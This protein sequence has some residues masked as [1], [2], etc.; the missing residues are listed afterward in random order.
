M[1]TQDPLVGLAAMSCINPRVE[2]I[3]RQKSFSCVGCLKWLTAKLVVLKTTSVDQQE[4]M[5][6]PGPA[7]SSRLATRTREE[8]SSQHFLQKSSALSLAS[9]FSPSSFP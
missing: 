4:I 1:P 2:F 6:V 9:F 5:V 3:H 8:L 7:R